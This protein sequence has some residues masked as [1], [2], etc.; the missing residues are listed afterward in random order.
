MVV[1][2]FV[3]GFIYM[4]RRLLARMQSRLGPNRTGPLGLLQPVADAVTTC[5]WGATGNRS[6]SSITRASPPC[7]ATKRDSRRHN[8]LQPVSEDTGRQYGLCLF[9][10]GNIMITAT[11]EDTI[12]SFAQYGTFTGRLSSREWVTIPASAG[13]L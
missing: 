2:I 1:L 3:M 4:E 13:V 5:R 8:I 11:S 7:A 9:D 6:Y 12:N 10:S